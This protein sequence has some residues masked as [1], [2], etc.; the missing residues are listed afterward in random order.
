MNQYVLTVYICNKYGIQF[1][2]LPTGLYNKSQREISNININKLLY[3]KNNISLQLY[4][5]LKCIIMRNNNYT[6]TKTKLF[7]SFSDNKN[8]YFYIDT[9]SLLELGNNNWIGIVFRNYSKNNNNIHIKCELGDTDICT[10]NINSERDRVR[11]LLRFTW[12][13][14]NES[15]LGTITLFSCT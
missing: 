1:T 7:T 14:F 5:S 12:G 15:N 4:S 9:I 10:S 3:I 8:I 13:I 6:I 2:D 11:S